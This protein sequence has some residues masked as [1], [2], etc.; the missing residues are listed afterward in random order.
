MLTDWMM[1]DGRVNNTNVLSGPYFSKGSIPLFN[2]THGYPMVGEWEMDS[3]IKVARRSGGNA[4][5]GLLAVVTDDM[6]P[7]YGPDR[8]DIEERKA[9]GVSIA[10]TVDNFIIDM[11]TNNRDRNRG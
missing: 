10:K 1:R 2:S 3:L 11:F 6:V 4:Q 9:W 7:R 8:I 5:I